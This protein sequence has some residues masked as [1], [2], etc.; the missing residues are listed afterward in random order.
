MII[1]QNKNGAWVISEL[2]KGY[3]ETRVYYFYNKKEAIKKFKLEMR[4][5]K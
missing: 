2:I 1:E 5:L 3:W 4:Y